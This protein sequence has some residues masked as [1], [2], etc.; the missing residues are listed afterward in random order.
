MDLLLACYLAQVFDRFIV[1]HLMFTFYLEYVEN[2]ERL[3]A[4]KASNTFKL[5]KSRLTQYGRNLSSSWPLG[6]NTKC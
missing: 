5:C 4:A 6:D 2:E 3:I 1:T